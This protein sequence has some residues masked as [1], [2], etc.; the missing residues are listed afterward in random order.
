LRLVDDLRAAGHDFPDPHGNFLW[1]PFG[2]STDAVYLGLEQ[3]GVV[4]RPFSGE[5]IRV[6]V[7][8]PDEND[9]FRAT[10]AEVLDGKV[11]NG[12]L[13]GGG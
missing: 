5:G 11:L 4:T 2:E 3:R 13:L 12:G 10:L 1:L 6:T 8:S 9:R 7:G